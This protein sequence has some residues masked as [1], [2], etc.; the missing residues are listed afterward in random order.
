MPFVPEL[1]STTRYSNRTG[2]ADGNADKN[3]DGSS[4]ESTLAAS[5][6][7]FLPEPIETTRRT[8][9]TRAPE[10][11]SSS[12]NASTPKATLLNANGNNTNSHINFAGTPLSG[13]ASSNSNDINPV[14]PPATGTKSR[15]LPEPVETTRRSNRTPAAKVETKKKNGWGRESDSEEE[16]NQTHH[17]HHQRRIP[18]PVVGAGKSKW[19]PAD[20]DARWTHFPSPPT[21]G[22]SPAGH[23]HV[24]VRSSVRLSPT[25][26]YGVAYS[27]QAN[28][29]NNDDSYF[30]K[31]LTTFK[32]P[33][34]EPISSQVRVVQNSNSGGPG[35]FIRAAANNNKN[36]NGNNKNAVAGIIITASASNRANANANANTN[37]NLPTSVRSGH[38]ERV[39]QVEQV[40]GASSSSPLSSSP[41]SS[42][43]SNASE[44]NYL[45]DSSS[46][47][48]AIPS[49]TSS[50]YFD[51]NNTLEI[52]QQAGQPGLNPSTILI[53]DFGYRSSRPT[54]LKIPSP[55]CASACTPWPAA[56]GV[57]KPV[58]EN[59]IAQHSGPVTKVRP[60]PQTGP[61]SLSSLDPS[62]THTHTTTNTADILRDQVLA[63]QSQLIRDKQA[64]L[65]PTYTYTPSNPNSSLNSSKSSSA[66]LHS[67][68]P[69]GSDEPKRK[70]PLLPF[71]F[72]P[73]APRA[74]NSPL[75]RSPGQIRLSPGFPSTPLLCESPMP[76]TLFYESS[77]MNKDGHGD[78]F[79]AK[80][81]EKQPSAMSICSDASSAVSRDTALTTPSTRPSS[82]GLLKYG[83]PTTS[84]SSLVQMVCQAPQPISAE[85]PNMCPSKKCEVTT[86]FVVAVFNYLSLGHES[87]AK[88]FDK[89]LCEATGWSLE[90]VVTDRLGA[91]REYVEEYVDKKPGF[92]SGMGGW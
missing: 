82:P 12:S 85:P 41:A 77:K 20:E 90:R 9:R 48:S 13:G 35:Q 76:T 27:R 68:P 18:V 81:A 29:D 14:T 36:N 23:V 46:S 92:G 21:P 51:N 65:T 83:Y 91:L 6:P 75:L 57:P 42:L 70:K 7:R 69:N 10:P 5:K 4:S 58:T 45:L 30:P 86:E 61:A 24:H 44:P 37:A 28:I 60:L 25:A 19:F 2:D 89:E 64:L 38:D 50:Q 17:H 72:I 32:A 56:S 71:S 16:V 66:V 59:R 47:Q 11:S 53:R 54:P 31:H 26:A 34:E 73:A 39:E 79:S 40:A 63:A 84:T 43:K 15:F 1:V 55:A 62:Y 80:R 22:R 88:K 67:P 87:I 3:A 8:N 33:E 49:I 78:Y 74:L 52:S